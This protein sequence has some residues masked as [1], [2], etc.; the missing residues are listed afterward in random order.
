MKFSKLIQTI[1][2]VCLVVTILFATITPC[3]AQVS[4]EKRDDYDIRGYEDDMA[5]LD[6]FAIQLQNDPDATGY[7]IIYGG[8]QGR[9]NEAKQRLV[10]MKNYLVKNRGIQASRLVMIDGG[11]RNTFHCELWLMHRGAEPP[12]PTPTVSPKDV[13][14]K[15]SGKIN[16]KCD[17]GF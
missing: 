6:D 8:K 13:K 17:L 15:G 5:R 16:N 11:F 14:L 3:Y 4:L 10:C 1:F 2:Y 12:K 7:I 9:K